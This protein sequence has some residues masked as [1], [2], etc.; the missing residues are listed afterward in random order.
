M[1]LSKI[2]KIEVGEFNIVRLMEDGSIKQLGLTEEQYNMLT[3]FLGVIS[4]EKP[5]IL[6][7]KEYNL[8]LDNNGNV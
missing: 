4:K 7:G 2:R 3:H 8:K 6:L 1:K 5:L